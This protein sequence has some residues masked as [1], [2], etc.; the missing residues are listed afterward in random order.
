MSNQIFSHQ[1]YERFKGAGWFPEILKR[2]LLIVG[3]GG[4]ASWLSLLLA[5]CGANLHIYDGDRVDGINL[6]GQ[7]YGTSHIGKSKVFALTQV[8]DY[9]C[10]DAEINSYN[11]WYTEESLTNN[12]VL[13]GL[14]NM[15]ARQIVFQNWEEYVKERPDEKC[16]L[17][18][19]RL[20]MNLIQ[21]FCVTPETIEDY[22]RELPDDNQVADEDCTMKQTSFCAAM[23]ASHMV[24]FLTN[25]LNPI[26]LPGG[27]PFKFEYIIPINYVTQSEP[28]S[29]LKE[30]NNEL[31][32][33]NK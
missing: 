23:I 3:A 24:G 19:G 20:S 17:I 30:V 11:E 33:C 12:I 21:I 26:N 31:G 14:D 15:K 28:V 29:V 16:I 25:W 9:F 7:L 32:L 2:E 6:A 1:G 4:I 13:T 18:D 8:I 10:V 27:V 22:R 5:R